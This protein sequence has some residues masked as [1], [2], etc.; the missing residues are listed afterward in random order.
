MQFTS[1]LH[2][3]WTCSPFLFSTSLHVQCVVNSLHIYTYREREVPCGI[4]VCHH[5]FET[6]W[7][8]SSSSH[9]ID[10]RMWWTVS[11]WCHKTH[12]SNHKLTSFHSVTMGMS[13]Y[14]FHLHTCPQFSLGPSPPWCLIEPSTYRMSRLSHPNPKDE[15]LWDLLISVD[16]WEKIICDEDLKNPNVWASFRRRIRGYLR[17]N[18]RLYPCKTKS[19]HPWRKKTQLLSVC[20]C[21]CVYVYVYCDTNEVWLAG[22]S[23]QGPAQYRVTT[24]TRFLTFVY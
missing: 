7:L 8:R 9:P 24:T 23:Q 11:P 3:H 19:I 22:T 20:A 10:W 2:V 6:T 21:V 14:S 4:P 12:I 13:S 16:I 15:V 18:T 17:L 5:F 1:Q